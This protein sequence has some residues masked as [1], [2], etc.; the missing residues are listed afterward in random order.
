MVTAKKATTSTHTAVAEPR[1]SLEEAVQEEEKRP[2]VTQVVEVVEEVPQEEARP[3]DDQPLA[4]TQESPL[5]GE[6]K[7]KEVVDEIFQR[8]KE[9]PRMM[10]EITIHTK[11]RT[12]SVFLWALGTIVACLVVG[13]ALLFMS[14]KTGSL[15]SVVVVPTPTPTPTIQTTPT[16]ATSGLDRTAITIQVLNGGGKAGAA[17]KMKQALE[18]KG[19]TVSDTG[20]ADSYSYEKTEIQVKAAKSAYLP[21]LE[22]DLQDTYTLGTSSAKLDESVGYDARVIVGKE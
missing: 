13:A 7:R 6:E 11:R 14:G 17:T 15:P 12:P 10:P 18:D 16:P 19:Y 2:S 3:K 8:E 1:G 5:M 9:E 4:E 22:N 21:L 20:N